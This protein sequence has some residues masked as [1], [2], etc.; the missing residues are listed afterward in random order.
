MPSNSRSLLV[1]MASVATAI[2][3]CARKDEAWEVHGTL[4]RDRLELVA[5]SHEQIIDIPVKEGD[6]VAAGAVVLRQEAGTMQPRLD[7]AR[8]SVDEAG[9][10]LAELQ[11]GPRQREIDEARAALAGAESALETETREYARVRSLVERKL[12]SASSLDQAQARRDAARS[13][14]DQAGS[15]LKLL[16]EGTRIEQLQQAQAALA[17][18]RAAFAE[19]ETTAAR[20]VVHAPR[21]GTIEALPYKLGE[22]PPAGAPVVVMLADGTPYARVHVP[23]TLRARFAAGSRVLARVDGIAEPLAGTVRYISAEA[24]FTPYYALT[25]KD[26]TRLSYLAEVTLDDA[27]AAALPAGIP[28]QVTLPKPAAGTP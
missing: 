16:Q 6:H 1:L 18:S 8:A 25:Q 11:S 17:R 7:Q 20:Y 9:R 12:V 2:A 27:R 28:V 23:E 19:L 10:H 14:R 4:E 21:P 24:A 13:S 5:E 22:R 3:G 15:R 26:R